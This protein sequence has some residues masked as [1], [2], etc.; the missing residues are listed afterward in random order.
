M[1]AKAKLKSTK[2][3][4]KVALTSSSDSDSHVA[5]NSAEKTKV[6]SFQQTNGP[7]I[8]FPKPDKLVSTIS[9]TPRLITLKDLQGERGKMQ[10]TGPRSSSPRKVLEP[11]DLRHLIAPKEGTGK[12][13]AIEKEVEAELREN[14]GED[15]EEGLDSMSIHADDDDLLDSGNELGDLNELG[16]AFTASRFVLA[17]FRPIVPKE[18]CAKQSTN[19]CYFNFSISGSYAWLF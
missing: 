19:A 13:S 9:T 3:P 2:S 11:D 16:K 7:N 4:S 17:Y 6:K 15:L 12:E 5:K 14:P 8:F 1:N 18:E 10:E